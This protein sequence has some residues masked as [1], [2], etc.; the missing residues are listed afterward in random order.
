MEGKKKGGPPRSKWG[1]SQNREH[2]RKTRNARTK[3]QGRLLPKARKNI[4]N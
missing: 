1:I 3:N 2:P 4:S